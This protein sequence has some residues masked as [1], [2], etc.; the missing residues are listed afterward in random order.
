MCCAYRQKAVFLFPWDFQTQ[1]NTIIQHKIIYLTI[2]TGFR[3]RICWGVTTS[4]RLGLE[5]ISLCSN[6]ANTMFF[7]YLLFTQPTSAWVDSTALLFQRAWLLR[8][9]AGDVG[10][11]C[12]PTTLRKT[13]VFFCPN[14]TL[15]MRCII[16]SYYWHSRFRYRLFCDLFKSCSA[17]CNLERMWMPPPQA[18]I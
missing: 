1:S 4:Q 11:V 7:L 8:H 2:I 18:L 16:L 14:S 12:E 17:L 5:R 13:N 15:A 10:P 6:Q 9:R 3:T